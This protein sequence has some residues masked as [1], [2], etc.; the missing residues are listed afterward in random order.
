[1]PRRQCHEEVLD[2]RQRVSQVEDR[3]A[4][5]VHELLNVLVEEK[6]GVFVAI[7]LCA[8]AMENEPGM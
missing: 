5:L 8:M 6:H 7:R 1:M 4:V 2:V 3:H